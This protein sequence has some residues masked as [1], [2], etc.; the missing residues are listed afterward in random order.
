M[1]FIFLTCVFVSQKLTGFDSE[2]ET[3]LGKPRWK[4]ASE[5]KEGS[6]VESGRV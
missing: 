1:T 6:G 3:F 2:W 5:E 4:G